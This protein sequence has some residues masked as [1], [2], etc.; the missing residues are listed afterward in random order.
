[1]DTTIY[2]KFKENERSFLRVRY[3]DLLKGMGLRIS[4]LLNS[5]QPDVRRIDVVEF[6]SIEKKKYV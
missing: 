4:A 3:K 1:M 2:L 5:A 6:R